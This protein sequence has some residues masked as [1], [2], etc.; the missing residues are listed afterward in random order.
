MASYA[1]TG[2][3]NTTV[4]ASGST[5]MSLSSTA[6]AKPTSRP[7]VATS[8]SSSVISR[9]SVV[10]VSGQARPAAASLAP[11]ANQATIGIDFLSKT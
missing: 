3:T 8:S 1:P 7:T 11:L 6:D 4:L 2:A 9:S 5:S 10:S